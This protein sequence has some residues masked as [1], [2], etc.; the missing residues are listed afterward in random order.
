ME[1]KI[2]SKAEGNS[3][4][5]KIFNILLTHSFFKRTVAAKELAELFQQELSRKTAQ[6]GAV[7]V[8]ASDRLPGWRT[9]V[10]WRFKGVEMK[11]YDVAYM[12]QAESPRHWMDYEWYDESSVEQPVADNVLASYEKFFKECWPRLIDRAI[13]D[14][15]E[16]NSAWEVHKRRNGLMDAE[17]PVYPDLE[18]EA[19][20]HAKTITNNSEHQLY[21]AQGY[22][23]AMKKTRALP[24]FWDVAKAFKWAAEY[25]D[26]IGGELWLTSGQ[27]T[28][29]SENEDG[30]ENEPQ[31]L[32]S[33][34]VAELYCLQKGF[35][36]EEQPGREVGTMEFAE[37]C[38]TLYRLTKEG[39]YDNDGY[40]H[41]TE[42]LLKDFRKQKRNPAQWSGEKEVKNG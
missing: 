4:E 40:Y 25:R 23:N 32:T 30:N 11:K 28:L 21:V 16:I 12:S 5:D 39:W 13:T 26:E 19:K 15:R 41:T 17:Q 42:Q 18:T 31:S 10:K 14:E 36:K 20:E 3:I 9:P 22:Y 6:P 2:E 24:T 8:K 35:D 7:W 37:W 38:G 1:N 27:W 29:N 34:N 33:G